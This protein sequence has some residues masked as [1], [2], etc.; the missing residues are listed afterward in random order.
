MPA[1]QTIAVRAGATLLAV[2]AFMA[3]ARA[4]QVHAAIGAVSDYVVHG[5][6]RSLGD[7]AVQAELAFAG[8]RGMAVGLWASSANLNPGPG[9]T[10]E[11]GLFLA[12]RFQAGMDFSVDLSAFRYEYP[13][14]A[15]GLAYAYTQLRAALSYRETLELAVAH[16]PDWS[17]FTR[18]GAARNRAA[19]W[20]E[21]SASWPLSARASITGGVGYA[22]LRRH[23]DT[24]YGYY[25]AG[26]EWRYRRFVFGLGFVGAGSR[27]KAIFG[28]TRAG[29]RLV[30]SVIWQVL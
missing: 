4:Q 2:G 19:T 7:P 11:Y 27:G 29:D 3:P 30:G 13:R 21:L 22:D 26:L 24:G 5:V 14:D 10:Q 25:S 17:V 20:I 1:A 6:S 9:S 15:T 23:A 8:R 12:Q 18:Y 28:P 16:S